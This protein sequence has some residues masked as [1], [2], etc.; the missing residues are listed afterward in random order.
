MLVG[1]KNCDQ[2]S[3]HRQLAQSSNAM[4]EAFDNVSFGI[5][6]L[7]SH[8]E[9]LCYND[10]ITEILH[11]ERDKS[12]MPN[13]QELFQLISKKVKNL[14]DI[15][16]LFNIPIKEYF[17]TQELVVETVDDKVL[18]CSSK[19][20]IKNDLVTGVVWSMSD[21]TEHKTQE[22]IA[23]YKSLHDALTQLP[24]RSYLFNTLDRMTQSEDQDK[25]AVLFLDLDNFKQI[26]DNYGHPVGDQLLISCAGRIRNALR[27]PDT[28][29]RLSGDEFI[30]IL[31]NVGS[32][33]LVTQVIDRINQSFSN[34]FNLSGISLDTSLSIGVTFFPRNATKSRELIRQSD[35]AMYQAKR[36]GKN[37]FC[38]YEA[39]MEV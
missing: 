18:Y 38:F 29:A 15:E 3:Q 14:K 8:G 33:D 39:S 1:N 19:S 16:H 32:P 10:V 12:V 35:L 27:V 30:I 26:N 21:I 25:F 13:K 6:Y 36:L 11:I 9:I 23:T 22:R 31:E 24:N 7:N 20:I 4:L 17:Q 28:L 2:L 34:S 37:T 5:V